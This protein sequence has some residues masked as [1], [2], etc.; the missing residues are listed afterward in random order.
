MARPP[1]KER[2]IYARKDADGNTLWYCRVYLNGRDQREGPFTTKTDAKD[3]REDLRA[4]HRQGTVDPQGGWQLLDDLID[5]HLKLKT[6]KKDQGSQ[7]R[8][9]QWW[10]ERF[11]ATGVKRVKDLTDR[12]LEEARD[13]LKTERIKQSSTQASGTRRRRT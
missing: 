10:K 11:K 3:K 6:S 2:G 9:S 8:F 13:D 7:Q 1:K 4:N 5:R 12:V